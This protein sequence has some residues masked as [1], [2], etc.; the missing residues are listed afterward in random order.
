[1]KS[2]NILIIIIIQTEAKC[3]TGKYVTACIL[4]IC[5]QIQDLSNIFSIPRSQVGI[6]VIIRTSPLYD[7]G[8]TPVL[9]MWAE[10]AGPSQSDY[11]GMFSRFSSFPLSTK[12]TPSFIIVK[13]PYIFLSKILVIILVTSLLR[14]PRYYGHFF[15]PAKRPYIFL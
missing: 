13:Q 7:P 12:L 1:M 11:N 14:S 10:M 4:H 15:G 9:D 6:V 3:F 8:L 5:N 2:L